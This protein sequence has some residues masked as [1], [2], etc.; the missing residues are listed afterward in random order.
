[1]LPEI[2][3]ALSSSLSSRRASFS[4]RR[5]RLSSLVPAASGHGLLQEV[6][7]RL[8]LRSRAVPAHRSFARLF[9]AR[10]SRALSRRPPEGWRIRFFGGAV[11]PKVDQISMET[12]SSMIFKEIVELID[13]K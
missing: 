10:A 3:T 13:G 5:R 1:L 6:P 2:I 8:S 12:L 11:D 9:R 7:L 4:L